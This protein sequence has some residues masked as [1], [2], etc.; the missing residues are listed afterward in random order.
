MVAYGSLPVSEGLH[1]R[2]RGEHA[3]PK[4]QPVAMATD[5]REPGVVLHVHSADWSLGFFVMQRFAATTNT[6]V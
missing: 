6:G 2:G 3:D 1:Q 4:P 5:P